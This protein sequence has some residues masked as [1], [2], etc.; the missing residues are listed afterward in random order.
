MSMVTNKQLSLYIEEYDSDLG[1]YDSRIYITYNNYYKYFELFY[2]RRDKFNPE[3]TLTYKDHHIV[4]DNIN[5]V[6]TLLSNILC[7]ESYM[8]YT[9]YSFDRDELSSKDFNGYLSISRPGN[10]LF[11]YDR[12]KLNLNKYKKIIKMLVAS[13]IY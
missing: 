2:T 3:K 8:N 10:E 11:G 4:L 13:R 5:G 6:M 9:L 12:Q 7:K 1:S